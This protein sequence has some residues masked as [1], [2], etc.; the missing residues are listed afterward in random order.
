MYISAKKEQLGDLMY[1][2]LSEDYDRFVNWQNRLAVEI[3]FILNQLRMANADQVLDAATG[4]GMH[5]VALAQHGYRVA[6]ADISPGMI[7]HACQNAKAAGVAARFEITSFGNLANTFGTG[8]FDALLCLGN[9]LPHLISHDTLDEA[10]RDFNSCLRP[11]GL[12][13]I[14]NRNFDSV[15]ANRD[16]WMDPQGHTEDKKEWIFQRFYDFDSDGLLTFNMVIL[17]RQ[18]QGNWSQKVVSSRMRPIL[19]VELLLSLAEAGFNSAVY[20]G[21]MSGSAFDHD[22]SPNLVVVARKYA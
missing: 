8:T 3:P 17:K 7:E 11:G 6:G 5:A 14:Q 19:K 4:T 10:L 15:V 2:T 18:G 22:T 1:E 21:D 9:S 16:R 13:L 20:Y 12:V